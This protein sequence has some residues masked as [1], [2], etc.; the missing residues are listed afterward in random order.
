[1]A[2]HNLP[3]P[4]NE[5]P[6][7]GGDFG[8]VGL[9]ET[10]NARFR[11]DGTLE[12]GTALRQQRQFYFINFQAMPFLET[13]FRFGER[14]NGTTGHG[15][16]T[17][18]GF[19]AKFRLWQEGNW[20]PALALGLQDLAG[21]GIYGGEYLVASKRFGLWDFGSLDVTAGMGWG[22]FGTGNDMPNPL[23]FTNPSFNTR[24]RNVGQG[25]VPSWNS[26]FHGETV[27]VMGGLEWTAPPI[28][29][30]WGRFEGLRGKLEYA[31]DRLRDERYKYP[32]ITYG[33]C[34][35]STARMR[36]SA[37]PSASIRT[38]RRRS[39]ASR[40]RPCCRAPAP[41]CRRPNAMR[42]CAKGSPR[43]ASISWASR[44]SAAARGSRSLGGDS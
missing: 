2:Q 10:R 18:R 29:T 34:S 6:A 20:M 3:P 33:L 5:I 13:T 44:S 39:T 8:G 12:A 27:G 32:S 36:C 43:R 35:S 31:A 4:N 15:T 21:T 22:R 19:D 11:A 14:L 16:T 9:I 23:G 7:S 1:M 24:P 25:G 40:R 37:F 42:C 26:W 17:D 28:E 38:A 30:P 41:I